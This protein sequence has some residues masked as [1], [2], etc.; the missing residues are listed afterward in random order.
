MC[1]DGVCICIHAPNALIC[2][3]CQ[4]R[5]ACFEASMSI[6]WCA[7]ETCDRPCKQPCARTHLGAGAG[8][9]HAGGSGCTP[10]STVPADIHAPIFFLPWALAAR[11]STNCRTWS[12]GSSEARANERGGQTDASGRR[13]DREAG[14]CCGAEG[15][16]WSRENRL[17]LGAR[18]AVPCLIEPRFCEAVP[19]MVRLEGRRGGERAM[20]RGIVLILW[21]PL[22]AGFAGAPVRWLPTLGGRLPLFC[23]FPHGIGKRLYSNIHICTLSSRS[24]AESS[25]DREVQRAWAAVR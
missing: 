8:V 5:H 3:G 2:V 9:A 16:W 13:R 14:E 4:H 1:V 7:C 25:S 6:M 18:G 21:A 17:S 15:A 11:P 20:K 24:S 12:H 22:A 10:C 19:S 23:A